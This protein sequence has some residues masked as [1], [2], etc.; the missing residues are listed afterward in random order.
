MRN[1]AFRSAKVTRLSRSERRRTCRT[2]YALPL[3]SHTNWR[4][5]TDS[6]ALQSAQRD[7]KLGNSSAERGNERET[8]FN[9]YLCMRSRQNHGRVQ[10]GVSVSRLLAQ[11][12]R[13]VTVH[14]TVLGVRELAPAFLRVK[15]IEDARTEHRARHG[16]PRKREQAPALQSLRHRHRRPV[17]FGDAL[18]GFEHILNTSRPRLRLRSRPVRSNCGP[19]TE[20]RCAH[21]NLS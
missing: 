9:S 12:H 5:S 16:G 21:S 3:D 8:A 14:R 4:A 10:R 19:P 7:K 20:C 2:A 17:V 18:P 13:V 1:V 11:H 15:P 6:P